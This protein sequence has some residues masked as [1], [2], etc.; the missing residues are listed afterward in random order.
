MYDYSFQGDR[1]SKYRD[2]IGPAA[3][4]S[5]ANVASLSDTRHP[6]PFSDD[7]SDGEEEKSDPKT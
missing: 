1:A 2:R 7:E 6:T 3:L 5:L 4:L